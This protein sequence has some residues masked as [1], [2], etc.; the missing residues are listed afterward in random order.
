MTNKRNRETSSCTKRSLMVFVDVT[1]LV[2][3]GGDKVFA[4]DRLRAI[5]AGVPIPFGTRRILKSAPIPEICDQR[6]HR[7]SPRLD[8][9][10]NHQSYTPH[11]AANFRRSNYISNPALTAFKSLE[12]HPICERASW[13]R[14][15]PSRSRRD[16]HQHLHPPVLGRVRPFSVPH[17]RVQALG[18]LDSCS[19]SK[20]PRTPL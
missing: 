14:A 4:R 18:I 16:V 20:R 8:H 13:S 2:L 10:L 6:I 19:A 1:C 11:C 17:C 7:N 5:P 12:A 3:T 9:V 15:F